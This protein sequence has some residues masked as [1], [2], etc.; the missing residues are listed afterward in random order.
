LN[1]WLAVL[2]G[3]HAYNLRRIWLLDTNY[4]DLSFLFTLHTGETRNAHLDAE[5]LAVLETNHRGPYFL[6]LHYQDI[7][8]SLVLGATGSGKSFFLNFLITN[9]QK[10][11]PLTYIFDL[12]GSYENL[13][14]LFQGTY[15]PVGI[16]KRSFTINPFILPPTKE[17]LQFLSSFL[18]VLVESGGYQIT[19]Q[20]ERDLYEQIENLYVIDPDQRRLLTLS[21]MLNRNLR[22]HLQKWVQGGQYETLMRREPRQEALPQCPIL[23]KATPDPT[24][25]LVSRATR[26][27]NRIP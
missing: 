8:H 23:V 22:T 4:A 27:Q 15:L 21:N 11:Q 24:C 5:Y 16:E 13:T 2:P 3:N 18:K 1:A 19:A 12:G 17:N 10:Y 26:R 6:N 14:R 7:A 25:G 20:D 9:L